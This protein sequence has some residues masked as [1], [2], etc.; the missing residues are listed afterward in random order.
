[1]RK[2]MIAMA[3]TNDEEMIAVS[4]ENDISLIQNPLKNKNF[5]VYG[6]S[7]NRYN[8]MTYVKKIMTGEDVEHNAHMDK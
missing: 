8:Y 4:E 1:M 6:P 5:S 7:E 2:S 3:F